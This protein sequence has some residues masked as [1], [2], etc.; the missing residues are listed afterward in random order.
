MSRCGWGGD[1]EPVTAGWRGS[2]WDT[3]QSA[4]HAAR[5][6]ALDYIHRL[7]PGFL[8][9][10]GDRVYGDDPAVVIGL[11][12]LGGIPVAVIGQ[13]RD[14]DHLGA[15]AALRG[16]KGYR[17]ADRMMRLAAKFRLPLLTFIDMPAEAGV[18]SEGA[19]PCLG[20]GALSGAH[21]A[22]AGADDCGGD[23]RGR[24]RRCARLWRRRSC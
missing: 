10:H 16:R 20:D 23:R 21:V 24:Q 4:R 11:G 12:D 6:T 8:E 9:L 13:E 1:H 19:R 3:V 22:A 5:P 2:A 7:L 15:T 14:P 17:K 18:D